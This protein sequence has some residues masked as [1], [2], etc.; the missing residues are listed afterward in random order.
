MHDRLITLIRFPKGIQGQKFFQKHWSDNLPKFVETV[1][2]F[3]EHENKD[4]DFLLCNNLS[5]LLWLGQIADLE[6]H[7]THTRINPLPDAKKLPTK[8]T[9]SVK[10]LENSLMNYPDFM[11]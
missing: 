8:L 4:Q 3:T 10:N 7:T 11:V 5:S 1:R 6:L 9:G 2:V